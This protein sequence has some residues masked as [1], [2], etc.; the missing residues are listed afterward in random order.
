[1]KKL[2]IL[3]LL[4]FI[5]FSYAQT[6][7]TYQAV[8]LNPKGQELPGADNARAPLVDKNICLQFK[9]LNGSAK[10]EYQETMNVTTDEFGMVNVVIGTGTLTGGTAGTFGAIVWNGNPKNLMVAVDITGSC[11]SLWK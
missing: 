6:G 11:S 8:I 3:F 9:I 5:A 4:F 10:I 1:M 7:I 2:Y